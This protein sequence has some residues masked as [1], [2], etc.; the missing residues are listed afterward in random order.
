MPTLSFL[1]THGDEALTGNFTRNPFAMPCKGRIPS[2]FSFQSPIW[3]SV[4]GCT[5]WTLMAWTRPASMAEEYSVS[6]SA[7]CSSRGSIP[8]RASSGPPTRVYCTRAPRPRCLSARA[9]RATT[10]SWAGYWAR[11]VEQFLLEIEQLCRWV[12]ILEQNVKTNTSK[13]SGLEGSVFFL[14]AALGPGLTTGL[15]P[16]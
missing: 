4:S 9:S 10:T 13:H 16:V 11:C 8:T 3:R 15:F 7:G 1:H 6:S 2:S 5:C 14:V 12:W